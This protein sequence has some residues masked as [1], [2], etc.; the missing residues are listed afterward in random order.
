MHSRDIRTSFLDYFKRQGHTIVPSCLAR[1]GR[2]P[3][4]PLHER[5]DEPV[6]G[7]VSRPREAGLHARDDVAEVHARQRQ[8]QRPRQRRAVAPAS[9]VLRDAGKL[10]LRRLLQG[11]G[12]SVCVGAPDHDVEA[13][14]GPALPDDLQGRCGHSPRRRRARD[15]DEARAPASG[16]RSLGWPR[17]SGRWARPVPAAGAPRFTTSAANTSPATRSGA[18]GSASAST[19]AATGSSRSGTTCSWS[20]TARRTARSRPS[21]RRPSTRAWASSASRR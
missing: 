5:G 6:Q 17:T 19:A 4:A 9:H 13:R 15:L 2:R 7:R 11:R 21:R 3:D 20:S 10:L 18:A 8:A 14:S 1:A 12:H 16:S